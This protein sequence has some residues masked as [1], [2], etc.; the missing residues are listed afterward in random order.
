MKTQEEIIK[1]EFD[2]NKDQMIAE[3]IRLR[4]EKNNTPWPVYPQQPWVFPQSPGDHF[5]WTFP[6]TWCKSENK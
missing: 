1:F 3:I 6:G 4:A 5:P 2:D